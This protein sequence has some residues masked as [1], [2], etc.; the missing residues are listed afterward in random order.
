MLSTSFDFADDLKIIRKIVTGGD[1]FLFQSEINQLQDWCESNLDFNVSKCAIM[2]FTH[3][4]DKYKLEYQYKIGDAVLSRVNMKRNLGILIDGKL[5]FKNY[6]RVTVR[7][8]N[9][10]R[11]YFS[12]WKAFYEPR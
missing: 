7:K 4:T 5:S 10:V 3:K 11:F 8:W 9:D 1:C 2:S 6:T 12:L